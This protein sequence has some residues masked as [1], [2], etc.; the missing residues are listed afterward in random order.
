MPKGTLSIT[1]GAG[2][3]KHPHEPSAEQ[4]RKEREHREEKERI[5]QERRAENRRREQARREENRKIEQE[6]REESERQEKERIKQELLAHQNA[7]QDYPNLSDNTFKK[8]SALTDTQSRT[9]PSLPNGETLLHLLL[10]NHDIDN[11]LLLIH[12]KNYKIHMPQFGNY[13]PLKQLSHRPD[14]VSIIE[15]ITHL[16]QREYDFLANESLAQFDDPTSP[17]DSILITLLHKNVLSSDIIKTLHQKTEDKLPAHF[18]L[19]R[20]LYAKNNI[21]L[22]QNA[23]KRI[24][25]LTQLF[26]I[27]AHQQEIVDT[28]LSACYTTKSPKSSHTTLHIGLLLNDLVSSHLHTQQSAFNII[29]RLCQKNPTWKLTLSET[30]WTQLLLNHDATFMKQWTQLFHNRCETNQN[31][32]VSNILNIVKNPKDCAVILEPW[33]SY[34]IVNDHTN[35]T[36]LIEIAV[37]TRA[38][39]FEFARELLSQSRHLIQ[40]QSHRIALLTQLFTLPFSIDLLKK[41][42]YK[43]NGYEFE[44]L[45]NDLSHIQQSTYAIQFFTQTFDPNHPAKFAPYSET[46]LSRFLDNEHSY[47][48]EILYPTFSAANRNTLRNLMLQTLTTGTRDITHLVDWHLTHQQAI[49]EKTIFVKANQNVRQFLLQ[50]LFAVHQNQPEHIK[51]HLRAWYQEDSFNLQCMQTDL[52]T[53]GQASWIPIMLNDLIRH[54]NGGMCLTPEILT[55]IDPSDS[56]QSDL[57]D[58]LARLPNKMA[59]R[60]LLALAP[61][62]EY[63][64][65]LVYRHK[66]AFLSEDLYQLFGNYLCAETID[67]QYQYIASYLMQL[68]SQTELN[69]HPALEPSAPP[70]ETLSKS[71]EHMVEAMPISA[72]NEN[73]NY[74]YAEA[75]VMKEEAFTDMPTEKQHAIDSSS[76]SSQMPVQPQIANTT[77][78]KILLAFAK[79]SFEQIFFADDTITFAKQ[80]QSAWLQWHF[81]ENHIELMFRW[82]KI[83]IICHVIGPDASPFHRDIERFMA[84]PAIQP[85][86]FWQSIGVSINRLGL[87]ASPEATLYQSIYTAQKANKSINT[88]EISEQH[89]K[90]EST[91]SNTVQR[92]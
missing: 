20:L 44:T 2:K 48:L 38:T 18:E 61:T 32:L 84:E 11:F 39:H 82:A 7:L 10:K 3:K 64:L 60:S 43:Q 92:L 57:I 26:A 86:N 85:Q 49:F 59:I 16:S 19:Y 25:F 53:I 9:P 21:F 75:I 50:R 76:S 51:H 79:V 62:I 77:T 74:V 1:I 58:Q 22:E 23:A 90:A 91:Y 12:S 31:K 45:Y 73:E 36:A 54:Q 14:A 67:Q 56:G 42:Y 6:R 5:E 37:K 71:T 69:N 35:Y 89:Q 4:R 33:L 72:S 27:Y 66:N 68:Q 28:T 52:E 30:Q 63:K 34:E 46:F 70:E 17:C 88:I 13:N 47:E 8:L 65:T 78:Q 29:K 24:I 81:L 80:L 15:R 40:N 83:A 55:I 87:F 41:W